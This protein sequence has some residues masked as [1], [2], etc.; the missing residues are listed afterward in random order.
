MLTV[1]AILILLVIAEPI[2]SVVGFA[3]LGGATWI[4]VRV[5]KRRLIQYGA[6]IQDARLRMIKS[7]N[8]GLGAIKITKTLGRESYFLSEFKRQAYRS[9]KAQQ[10]RQVM[11]D[12]PR[13]YLETAA[14]IGLLVVAAILIS[15]QRPIG[16]II[17]TLSLLAV[18]VVRMIP[19][20]NRITSSITTLRYG[21]FSLDVVFADLVED[22]R[23]A[24]EPSHDSG[25]DIAFE[26]ELQLAGI[27]YSYPG[28]AG[29]ALRDVTIRV[30]R[31]E[32]V[33]IVGPTGCGKTTVVDVVLGLLTPDEGEV[34]VDGQSI[35]GAES[36]WRRHIGYVP[37]D[38]Y[39]LDDTIRRNIAFGLPD[40]MIDANA[41]TRAVNASQISGLISSLPAGL[42]TVVGE[43]GVRLSGGQR[44]R[45]GIARALYDNPAIVIL[46]EAT[47]SLDHETE[48]YVMEAIDRLRGERTLMIIA[49][50]ISTV[51]AC[52]RLFLLTDG[53][54][55]SSGT[56]DELLASNGQ[57]RR[58]AVV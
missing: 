32:A 55:V 42:D 38:V 33:G 56:Y 45:I 11:L 30:S 23:P 52:D 5:V 8:E 15:Q 40:D 6:A 20:F 31:G 2:V 17:P 49:H 34:L 41:V 51:R 27:Q 13:L 37:Q 43:R 18:A 57:F 21:R 1:A 53:R 14:M 24:V 28:S 48:R 35:R 12:V 22:G 4:S 54:V 25:A 9:A 50:R 46:D 7:V 47:S 58:L 10:F 26:R 3:L 39:L 19:S 16:S 44:Q 36:R 29:P